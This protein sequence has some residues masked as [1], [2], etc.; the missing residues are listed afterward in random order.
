MSKPLTFHIGQK[1]PIFYLRLQWTE[2]ERGRDIK[3]QRS[4]QFYNLSVND[5]VESTISAPVTDYIDNIGGIEARIAFMVEP[6]HLPLQICSHLG[7]RE[8]GMICSFK[9]SAMYL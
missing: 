1:T 8:V 4:C 5:P 9:V 3:E 7:P 6:I 2:R